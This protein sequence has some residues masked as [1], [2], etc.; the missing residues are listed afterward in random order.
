MHPPVAA[1]EYWETDY[2][3]NELTSRGFPHL[4]MKYCCVSMPQMER[5]QESEIR[6]INTPSV[7]QA[8]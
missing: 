7:L 5:H 1:E 3:I 2:I 8:P 4:L 6:F